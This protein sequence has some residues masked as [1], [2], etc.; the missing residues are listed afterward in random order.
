MLIRMA[1]LKL[2]TGCP[3]SGW[4]ESVHD[5]PLGAVETEQGRMSP[6]ECNDEIMEKIRQR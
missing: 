1:E 4:T 6:E 3:E 5:S 2:E